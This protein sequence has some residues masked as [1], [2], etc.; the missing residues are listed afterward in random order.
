MINRNLSIPYQVNDC[1]SPM[2]KIF[3]HIGPPKTGTTTIQH[4]LFINRDRLLRH[5]IYLPETGLL[6]NIN[7][8]AKQENLALELS[9]RK[10]FRKKYGTWNDLLAEINR[11]SASIIIISSEDFS[12]FTE[13]AIQRVKEFLKD[14]DTSILFYARRQDHMFQSQWAQGIKS[15]NRKNVYASFSDW[16][17]NSDKTGLVNDYYALYQ[18]W[19]R[20]FGADHM[21][22]RVF[23]K[24]QIADSL[25]ED[26]LNACGVDA[27]NDCK[28][29]SIMNISPDA[30][31]LTL[32]CEYKRLLRGEL[33]E[34]TYHQIIAALIDYGK[35]SGWGKAKYTVISK[36]AYAQIMEQFAES[37][38]KLAQD[39][40]HRDELF[41]E[42]YDESLNFISI[43]NFSPLELIEVNT[44]LIGKLQQNESLPLRLARRL[45]NQPLYR[46]I[47]MRNERLIPHSKKG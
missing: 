13:D 35:K 6:Q 24:G 38:R 9:G 32:L 28:T 25:F 47:M 7:G 20:V 31:T 2:K 3:F 26:F 34:V 40:F 42:K 4:S 8:L 10:E 12:L 23:E 14:F 15:P 21:I 45:E 41:F 16:M 22:V 33:A 39:Y 30:K 18:R 43:D 44:Y 36:E 19:S 37:N 11:T 5:G 29:E 1:E 17:A 46:S 27:C